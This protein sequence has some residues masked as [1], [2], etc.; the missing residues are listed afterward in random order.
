M[1]GSSLHTTQLR[2]W[3]ERLRAGDLSAR[4]EMLRATYARLE[5]LAR[6]MLRRFPAV[7]R[8]E[9]TGDLL[10]NALLRLL[11]AL[12]D[13]APTSVRD[14]FG[15]AAEQ[16]RRELLD[17]ARRYQARPVQGPSHAAHR[18][19]SNSGV[20]APDPPAAV[21]DPDL[22]KWCAF[23]EAVERLPSQQREVVGLI[24]YHG[25]TQAEVAEHLDHSKRT[26][27]RY[28]A[29]AMLTLHK[30]LKDL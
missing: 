23:H 18:G 16:M 30:R 24:Y 25:W 27:Q 28:W 12:Q 3:V 7:G 9:E 8:W 11:R 19:Q 2:R 13:I 26:V 10:Q 22:E 6:K 29:A 5:R 20:S 21:E 14:F 4:E 1:P 15:L 17:L